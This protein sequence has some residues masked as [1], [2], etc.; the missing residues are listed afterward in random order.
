MRAAHTPRALRAAAQTAAPLRVRALRRT[1]GSLA[2]RVRVGGDG[3]ATGARSLSAS[4]GSLLVAASVRS[5]A[6]PSASAS[7]ITSAAL[8]RRAVTKLAEVVRLRRLPDRSGPLP[9]A[10]HE[11]SGVQSAGRSRVGPSAGPVQERAGAHVAFPRRRVGD[12]LVQALTPCLPQI[13][14]RAQWTTSCGPGTAARERQT[15]PPVSAAPVIAFC[16]GARGAPCQ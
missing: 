13:G 7:A 16:A 2:G 6:M 12:V 4:M 3:A 5:P 8:P 10:S 1:L 9:Q 11:P 15:R 14:A